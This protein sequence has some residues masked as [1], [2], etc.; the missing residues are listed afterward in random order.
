MKRT[1]VRSKLTLVKDAI[2]KIEKNDDVVL[3]ITKDKHLYV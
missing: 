1:E 3:Y 2:S